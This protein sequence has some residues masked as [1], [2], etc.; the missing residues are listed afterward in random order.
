MSQSSQSQHHVLKSKYFD[1]VRALQATTTNTTSSSSS[2]SEAMHSLITPS[3]SETGEIEGLQGV[4]TALIQLLRECLEGRFLLLS[5]ATSQQT[6]RG[7]FHLFL[8][9]LYSILVGKTL[10]VI[11]DVSVLL[12]RHLITSLLLPAVL[13]EVV[14]CR[15]AEE[16]I[17]SV[18]AENCLLR[19]ALATHGADVHS[20]SSHREVEREEVWRSSLLSALCTR[21]LDIFTNDVANIFREAHLLLHPA[22]PPNATSS[23]SSSSSTTST[24]F[25]LKHH[26]NDL[27][28]SSQP[29]D[30]T[31]LTQRALTFYLKHLLVHPSSPPQQRRRLF[32][33]SKDLIEEVLKA[34]DLLPP[35]RSSSHFALTNTTAVLRECIRLLPQLYLSTSSFSSS[36]LNQKR[37]RH[38]SINLPHLLPRTSSVHPLLSALARYNKEKDSS[39]E[40]KE[41]TMTSASS[42]PQWHTS[43]LLFLRGVWGLTATDNDKEEKAEER[44]SSDITHNTINSD[45]SDSEEENDVRERSG[46]DVSVKEERQ[47]LLHF[48]VSLQHRL[49]YFFSSSTS[50]EVMLPVQRNS[51]EAMTSVFLLLYLL[52]SS[53]GK[54]RVFEQQLHLLNTTFLTSLRHLHSLLRVKLVETPLTSHTV[55]LDFID[56]DR[57]RVALAIHDQQQQRLAVTS[58]PPTGQSLSQGAAPSFEKLYLCSDIYDFYSLMMRLPDVTSFLSFRL[59]EEMLPELCTTLLLCLKLYLTTIP[60]NNNNDT[61]YTTSPTTTSTS[62]AAKRF[63]RSEERVKLSLLHFLETCLQNEDFIVLFAPRSDVASQGMSSAC[64]VV[65]SLIFYLLPF[66]AHTEVSDDV[67]GFT[68]INLHVERGSDCSRVSYIRSSRQRGHCLSLTYLRFR[69]Q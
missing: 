53:S 29:L 3:P 66:L 47:Q 58:L 38:V 5:L 43:F 28:T 36:L 31:A 27:Y 64:D 56:V 4:L 62:I 39:D 22:V 14:E 46:D 9:P 50:S 1:P 2:S 65:K 42:S 26:P 18:M 41:A 34:V 68:L 61:N 6:E 16:K 8:A 7:R 57:Q 55:R 40:R 21:H 44:E 60:D 24:S 51:A 33:L 45:I 63:V 15:V 67:T 12:P 49:T 54:R 13:Y 23:S 30:R 59:A 35:H 32:L 10:E 52:S 48:L 17:V 69:S 37:W 11:A 19:L 20:T 25:L